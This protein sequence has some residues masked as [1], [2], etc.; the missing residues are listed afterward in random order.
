L[1]K[2]YLSPSPSAVTDNW[3]ERFRMLVSAWKEEV[4][5]RG[6]TFTILVIPNK[7]STELAAKLIGQ[8]FA[9]NTVYLIDYFPEG[10]HNFTF[11]ND[12]HWNESGNLRAAQAIADWGSVRLWPVNKD[13]VEAVSFRTQA[14]IQKLYNR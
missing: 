2:D 10:F 11:E 3:A 12:N 13:K 14:A 7:V 4:E 9:D 5:S 8:H 6:S 1:I